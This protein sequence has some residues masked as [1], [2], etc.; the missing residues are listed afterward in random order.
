[1]SRPSSVDNTFVSG[2]NLIESPLCLTYP[3][4]RIAT[5]VELDFKVGA[6]PNRWCFRKSRLIALISPH[7]NYI[8]YQV[9]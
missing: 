9:L 3:L 7:G 8:L 6:V 5:R 1:M 2:L 4:R